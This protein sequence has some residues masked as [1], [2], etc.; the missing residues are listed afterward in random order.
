MV[1][2]GTYNDCTHETEGPE[3]TPACVI[4]KSG[5]TLRGAGPDATIIDA[6][7]LGRGIFIEDV[8]NC[9]VENLQVR[10][11][12][13]AIYGA[14]I[15]I[16]QVGI[17]VT[18]SDVTITDNLDGGLICYDHASPFLLRLHCYNNEAKQGGGISV[19]EFSSPVIESCTIENNEA[20]SG[21]GIFVR[22]QSDATILY[23]T[24]TENVINAAYGNGGGICVTMVNLVFLHFQLLAQAQ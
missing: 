20:P 11:A 21:A 14:G 6:Q 13:A 3:S 22:N 10:G 9:S 4:M 19:E 1:C 18:I 5:V 16:R 8:S 23:C 7:G 15:L 12:Y 2:A 24:I 17:D